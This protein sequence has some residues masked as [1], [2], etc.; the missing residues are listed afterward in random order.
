MK[1]Y[2]KV[3]RL[4]ALKLSSQKLINVKNNQA[5][6]FERT[7]INFKKIRTIQS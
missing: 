4:S 6:K 5:I 7:K 2:T 3:I 1:L